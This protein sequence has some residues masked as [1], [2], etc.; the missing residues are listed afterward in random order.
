MSDDALDTEDEEKDPTFDLDSTLK[1]DIDHTTAR[2]LQ[3]CEDW[4]T[5]L[6]RDDSLPWSLP[7]LSAD[8]GTQYG[9]DESSR[10]S[11]NDDWEIRTDHT[12]MEITLHGEWRDPIA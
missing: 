2:T 5:H 10:S 7:L 11:R 1:E 6:D 3:V 12:Q 9:R 4:V 8:Q